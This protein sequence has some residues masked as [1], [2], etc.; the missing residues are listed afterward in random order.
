MSPGTGGSS[1][2]QCAF[3]PSAASISVITCAEFDRFA[4][5]KVKDIER[6]TVILDRSH[7][8]LDDVFDVGKISPR[9]TVA[10]DVDWFSVM[11]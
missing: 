4:F 11:N 6:R 9:S 2:D 1:V 10:V 8:A 3:F 7:H 5:S